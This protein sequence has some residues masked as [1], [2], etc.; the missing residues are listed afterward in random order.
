MPGREGCRCSGSTF[1]SVYGCS[2]QLRQLIEQAGKWYVLAVT[3]VIRVWI[4]RPEVLEP[5]EQTGGRPRRKVRLAKS[6]AKPQTVAEVIAELPK[7]RWRRLSIGVG[8]KGPRLY[9]WVCLRVIE[10]YDDV[11]GPEVWLLARRSISKPEEIAYY[12]AFAPRTVSLQT[13]IRIAGTRY[14]VEQCIEEAKG[15]VGFDQ[16]EVRHYW[17]WYRHMTLALMAHTWLAAERARQREKNGGDQ[18]EELTV[19]EVRR[20]L[21]VALPLASRSARELLAWSYW[22][23]RKCYRARFCHYRH[24]QWP[25]YAGPRPVD[26]S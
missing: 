18:V 9:D 2:P 8:T 17:S 24:R 4:E 25:K 5:E 10:S 20:L 6:A 11:P 19:P 13:L 12:L 14:T 23:R 21:E 7:S 3:A 16:Y 22:R 1:D 15:E 26:S